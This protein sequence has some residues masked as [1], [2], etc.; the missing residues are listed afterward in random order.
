ML[1]IAGDTTTIE[2]TLIAVAEQIEQLTADPETAALLSEDVLAEWSPT[3]DTTRA[4][5]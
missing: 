5:S 4:P 1:E 2:E 3:R